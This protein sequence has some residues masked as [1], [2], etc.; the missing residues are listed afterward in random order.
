MQN[1]NKTIL[2]HVVY[3]IKSIVFKFFSLKLIINIFLRNILTTSVSYPVSASKR[4]RDKNNIM[5]NTKM[6]AGRRTKHFRIHVYENFYL[7]FYEQ[8]IYMK[9]GALL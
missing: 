5:K 6:A 4:S 7:H 1:K 8:N 2:I 9:F 3:F